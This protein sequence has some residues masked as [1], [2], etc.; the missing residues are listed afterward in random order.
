TKKELEIKLEA[1]KAELKRDIETAKIEMQRDIANI[2]SGIIQ[3]MAG[4]FLL[5]LG[6]IYTLIRFAMPH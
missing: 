4:F 6:S 3:W 5:Q 2:K 1:T